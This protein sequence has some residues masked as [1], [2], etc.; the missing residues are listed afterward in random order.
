MDSEADESET[1]SIGEADT[2]QTQQQTQYNADK[3]PPP[4]HTVSKTFKEIVDLIISKNAQYKNKFYLKEVKDIEAVTIFP[5]NLEFHKSF[6]EILDSNNIEYYTYTPKTEKLKTVVLK[7]L[8]G[9]YTEEEILQKL[10]DF[11]LGDV[12][13]VKVSKIMFS[14]ISNNFAHLI[15]VTNNSNINNL[16]KIKTLLFQ[17]VRW[18]PLRKKAPYQCKKC[19]RFG[20]SSINCSLA[21]RCIKC[22]ENHEPGNCTAPKDADKSQLKCANCKQPG[23]PASY[24][25]CTHYKQL[26]ETTKTGIL[27]KKQ[28][29]NKV[30]NHINNKISPNQTFAD[31]VKSNKPISQESTKTILLIQPKPSYPNHSSTD[32]SQSN[33]EPMPTWARIMQEKIIKTVSSI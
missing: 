24:G 16:T 15:Q 4:I 6:K 17:K 21:F 22:G 18:E 12:D 19:Q 32:N 1:E 23:H 2:Q 13:I 29:N 5:N 8:F 31:T 7:D 14:K 27:A 3:R 10:N 30:L 28:K 20:H 26:Y 9:N 33:P 11:Y 25:G